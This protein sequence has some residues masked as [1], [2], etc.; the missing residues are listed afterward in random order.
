MYIDKWVLE[1]LEEQRR[2]NEK[3]LEI[4][5][6]NNSYYVYRSTTYLDRNIKK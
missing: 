1:W 5:K 4:K 6:R 2:R 3:G